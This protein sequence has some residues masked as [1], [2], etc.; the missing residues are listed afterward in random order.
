MHNACG[1]PSS[2]Y[3]ICGETHTEYN[4]KMWASCSAHVLSIRGAMLSGPLALLV[5]TCWNARRTSSSL[6]WSL[7]KSS[8]TADDEFK[9][10]WIWLC[11]REKSW[12]SIST[13]S[14]SQRQLSN[15]DFAKR[16]TFS[17]FFFFFFC[18]FFFFFFRLVRSRIRNHQLKYS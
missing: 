11:F 8:F 1:L 5:F 3:S 17:S 4:A 16:F 14:S 6:V 13:V 12:Q 7:S 2:L 15:N 10:L 18:L 9:T